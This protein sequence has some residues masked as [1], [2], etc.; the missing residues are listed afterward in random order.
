M[1]VKPNKIHIILKI[2][3]FLVFS[4]GIL[5]I[6]QFFTQALNEGFQTN[7]ISPPLSGASRDYII[8]TA[9]CDVTYES[10]RNLVLCPDSNAANLV[11]AN[12][13]NNLPCKYDNVCITSGE[14]SSNY[15]TC[16]T[17]PAQPV[18]NDKYGIFRDFDPVADEDTLALDIA[19]D[20][21]AFCGA[22]TTNTVKVI[23]GITST[24]TV[25]SKI[26]G[27]ELST[28]QYVS[29]IGGLITDKCTP[30]PADMTDECDK[31]RT[32]YAQINMPQTSLAEAKSAT[33]ASLDTLSNI[34]TGIYSMYNNGVAGESICDLL[35]GYNLSSNI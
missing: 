13:S 14:F 30:A 5:Y 15:Y 10:G 25:Y 33:K 22:Y 18:Y 32:T 20:I 21:G 17:R 28:A 7:T 19:P 6:C 8:N 26:V 23:R 34:S 27:G 11:F 9:K 3:G 29:L 4:I 1:G 31:L 12:M 24:Q 2:F 16:Y 35:P